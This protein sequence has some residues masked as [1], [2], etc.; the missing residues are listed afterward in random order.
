M[1]TLDIFNNDAFGAVEMTRAIRRVPYVP[2]WLGSLGLFAMPDRVSTVFVGLERSA[3]KITL[4]QTSER[5]GPPD[6][7]QEEERDIVPLKIPRLA[8]R[9]R[10]QA[11]AIQGIRAFGS[12]T[13][14]EGV[15]DAVMRIQARQKQDLELTREY[16]RLGAIQGRLLDANGKLLVDFYKA[17][18]IAEP[19]EIDFEL[20]DP[21]TN[22]RAKCSQV[23]RGMMA[24]AKGLIL[25]S[26]RIH[27]MTGDNFFDSLT[28]HPQVRDTFKYQE[29]ARL[30]D[31]TAYST[32]D[33]GGI[34]FTNYRGTDDV[35]GTV[36]I[37]TDKARFFPVGAPDVFGL[38]LA[39]FESADFVNTPGEDEYAII[40]RDM[41]RNFWWQPE[42]YSYPLHYCRAP[43]LLFRAK[44]F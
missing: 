4:I 9:Q 32:L 13:E 29:G 3:G 27:A 15:Q 5:G 39:P 17:F 19:A 42:I 36:T 41:E 8:K 20:D 21:D 6:L 31:S 24:A 35:A 44:R 12:T 28:D 18:D 16:H 26:T 30:R 37:H 22:V 14:L 38:A 34:T 10:Q 1:A 23:T 2:A 33:Y 40:V 7:G 25:P 43:E 11:A